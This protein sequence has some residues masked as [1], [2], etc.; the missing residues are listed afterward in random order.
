MPINR[1]QAIQEARRYGYRELE[2]S[3]R[4]EGR[5]V[6]FH[7]DQKCG[8]V[9]INVYYT[10]GTVATCLDHPYQGKTQLFRRNQTLNDLVEIF[11]DPRT[12]TGDGYHRLASSG[13]KI[14]IK[15]A[16]NPC[17]LTRLDQ[18]S[19]DFFYSHE[20]PYND[21]ESISIGWD[22]SF[23]VLYT[24]GTTAYTGIPKGLDNALKGRQSWLPRPEIITIG[25]RSYNSYFIQFYDGQ[26]K[27]CD[28]PDELHD[29]LEND[30][31]GV[32]VIALGDDDNYYVRFRDGDEYWHLPTSL[33]NLLNGRNG[34]RRG[35]NPNLA[36]VAYITLSGDN[37]Y[38]VKFTNGQWKWNVSSTLDDDEEDMIRS[39]SGLHQLAFG[40]N[41]EFIMLY[42]P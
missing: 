16:S 7:H 4:D 24:D 14:P 8:G 22:S 18:D 42:D 36:E 9:R 38:A 29:H 19:E 35:A 33:S 5:M 27:W 1:G 25:L 40:C 3:K 41:N 17:T 2:V 31:S 15:E 10:T 21:I 13:Q 11:A 20:V 6:S 39:C 12:H 30:T 26:K 34:T 28:V 32:D 23:I 37:E